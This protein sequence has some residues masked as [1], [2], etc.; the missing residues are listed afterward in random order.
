MGLLAD[1]K[2]HRVSE[3]RVP[4]PH[5]HSQSV[6]FFLLRKKMPLFVVCRLRRQ[7]KTMANTTEPIVPLARNRREAMS[8]NDWSQSDEEDEDERHFKSIW[9]DCGVE[10]GIVV[11]WPGLP[12]PLHISTVLEEDDLAPLFHGTQ[13]AGTRVWRAAMIAIHYLHER[14]QTDDLKPTSLLELGCGLGVPGM[15]LHAL[16]PELQVVLTDQD[17]LTAQL[18]KNLENNFED[19]GKIKAQGLSWSPD[20]VSS[21]MQQA[22][23]GKFEVCLNCDCVYEPLYGESW[24][25]LADTMSELAKQNPSILLVTSVERRNADAVEKFVERLG[26]SQYISSVQRVLL[27][28]KDPHHP[29]E[30][31][32]ASGVP[33]N[34][35]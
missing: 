24:K 12:K 25:A 28:D 34:E 8:D 20:C 30:I 35:V 6:L 15:I 21:I 29:I 9:D 33:Q 16:I 11:S 31:Y 23:G 18:Q 27:D 13:W 32:I 19:D 26:Q 10:I 4:V 2:L 1:R 17:T 7:Q 22:E 14:Y 5:Y 3:S